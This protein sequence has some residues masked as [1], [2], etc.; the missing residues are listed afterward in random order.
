MGF[1]QPIDVAF[2]REDVIFVANRS[3]ENIPS[4]RITKLTLD[5]QFIC[6]FGRRIFTWIGGIAVDE[7]QNVYASDEWEGRISV[8]DSDGN[9]LHAWGEPGDGEGQL[10][11]SSGLVFDAND[12]LWVV[13][14]FNGRIQKFSK[15][16]LYL[17]GFGYKG[18]GIGEL[19][20]PW[21]IDTDYAGNLYVAD[22]NNHRV[23]KFSA[24]G[25]PLSVFGRSGKGPGS[26]NHPTSVAVDQ[27]G[28]VYVVDWMNER[29][30]IYDSDAK[31]LAY[32]HGDAVDLSKWAQMQVESN[33]DIINAR[34]RV[35]DLENQQR[36]FRLPM[37]CG[38]DGGT[39]R[40]V[41]CDTQRSRLQVYAKDNEFR[42]PQINL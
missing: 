20:M 2:A 17:G 25:T 12:D 26:L 6:E 14:S 13:N 15:N 40:L 29:I 27:D 18:S 7:A 16:G 8:F 23:Q 39:N 37:G 28:D 9:L 42:E 19:D 22:W 5:E 36:K 32:L 30:V 1:A 38:F 24:N 11:G 4:I 3:G 34:R 35:Y 31:I 33:P 21:G 41:V 10:C